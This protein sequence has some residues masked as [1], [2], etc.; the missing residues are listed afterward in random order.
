MTTSTARHIA[1]I[2]EKFGSGDIRLTTWQNLLIPHISDEQLADAQAA[3]KAVGLAYT[4]TT[5]SGGLIACTGNTGCKFAAANTKSQ[6]IILGQYLETKVKLD[7]PINIH[8]TGCHHSCAQHYIGDIG[9][10]GTPVKLESGEKVEGYNIVLGGGVDD[11]QAIAREVYKNIPFEK[12]PS[13]I[14]TL[15]KVYQKK[16]KDGETFAQYTQRE[17]IEDLVAADS[18]RQAS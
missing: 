1:N 12:I 13:I 16:R 3:I 2:A 18:I 8:L 7:Q 15:L 11:T 9:L 4:S 6:A 14:E 17:K 5:I 10:M